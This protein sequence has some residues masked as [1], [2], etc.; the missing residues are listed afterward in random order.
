[1]NNPGSHPSV[2]HSLYTVKCCIDVC[3]LSFFKD[4]LFIYVIMIIS[5]LNIV[6][7]L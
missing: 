4:I 3:L 6:I 2:F 1:M 5:I 7:T